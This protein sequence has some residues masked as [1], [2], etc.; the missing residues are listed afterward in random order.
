MPGLM[1]VMPFNLVITKVI[2]QKFYNKLFSAEFFNKISEIL[3]FGRTDNVTSDVQMKNKKSKHLIL[4][5][6]QKPDL[7]KTNSLYLGKM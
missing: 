7:D 4:T 1:I 5:L 3:R 2:K 6:Q